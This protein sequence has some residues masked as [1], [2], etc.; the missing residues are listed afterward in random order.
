MRKALILDSEPAVLSVLTSILERHDYS[1]VATAD[2]EFA[3]NSCRK[4]AP[5]VI[6]T[7]VYLRGISGHEA[8]KRFRE[9]CPGVPVLMVSGLPD[10]KVVRDWV[11]EEGFDVFPKPFHPKDLLSKIDEVLSSR[12][13]ELQGS[14]SPGAQAQA[15]DGSR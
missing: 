3:L 8:M 1:A 4:E 14:G 6:L 7:N 12:P 2:F 5:D 10:N 9:I 11:N 13:R 15:G